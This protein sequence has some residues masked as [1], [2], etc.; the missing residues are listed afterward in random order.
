MKIDDR[1]ILIDD[2]ELADPLKIY[3]GIAKFRPLE[4]CFSYPKMAM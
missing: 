1:K 3:S 4:N 2:I